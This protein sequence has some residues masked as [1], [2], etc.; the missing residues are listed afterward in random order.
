MNIGIDVMGGDYAPAEAIKG[1][2]Q[3]YNAYDKNIH[4]M[5]IGNQS[6]ILEEL[7][8]NP[9]PADAFTIVNTTQVIEMGEHP[10]KALAQK[11]NS[12]IAI[13]FQMLKEFKI[14]AFASAGNTGAMMVGTLFSVKTINGIQRPCISTVIPK[15]NGQMGVLLDVG[16]N[17]DVKPENLNQFATLGSIYASAILKINN[18]RVALLNLGQEEGKGS[19]LLQAAYNLLKANSNINFIGNIEGRDLFNESA[20]V[21]VCDGYVGN[22]VLKMAETYYE[23]LLKRK[24]KDEYFDRF[25]YEIYGGQPILGANA[26]VIIG[27]GISNAIAFK[28]MLGL[29]INMVQSQI[30]A[31][32]KSAITI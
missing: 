17:A 15:E 28:N 13:G 32:M 5:L 3:A 2:V 9:I 25:N 7:A 31:K 14:D 24:I 23:M 30:I 12:S 22:V 8:K 19:I 27:H 11:P 20:D 1:V 18:P 6:T 26:P 21:I 29:A 10:T 16:A 4:Y